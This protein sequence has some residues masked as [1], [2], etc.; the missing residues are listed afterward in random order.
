MKH[1]DLAIPA[2][3][4]CLEAFT[5]TDGEA[6]TKV[7][8]FSAS[9]ILIAI[10][11]NNVQLREFVSRNLFSAIIKGL[12]LDS[13]AVISADLVNLCREIFLYLCDR[14]PAPRQVRHNVDHYLNIF[15][16]KYL[17]VNN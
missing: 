10:L 15:G 13:N 4:I 5:W 17:Q 7:S 8:S 9:V 1:N 6:V 14:D 16:C 3:Q 11:T 12:A 2:L